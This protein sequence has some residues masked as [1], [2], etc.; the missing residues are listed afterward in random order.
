M[1]VDHSVR[2]ALAARVGAHAGGAITH[3]YKLVR[4]MGAART[5]L[6][7]NFHA[8][9]SDLPFGEDVTRHL[10][11]LAADS[12]FRT[13]KPSPEAV[14]ALLAS[15]KAIG[16]AQV[17]RQAR[18]LPNVSAERFRLITSVTPDEFE[19]L[20][21]LSNEMLKAAA[22]T[23]I[24]TFLDRGVEISALRA[25]TFRETVELEEAAE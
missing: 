14:T 13:K 23:G 22:A 2:H 17:A 6:N 12:R 9:V 8:L 1:S 15:L 18:S 5:Q 3:L 25:E 19:A 21:G 10:L 4:S 7:G 20:A 16:A 24:R 11:V